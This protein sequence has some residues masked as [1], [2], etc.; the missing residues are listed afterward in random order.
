M[1]DC[2]TIDDL[3]PN[4]IAQI[5]YNQIVEEHLWRV[6]LIKEIIDVKFGCLVTPEGWTYEELGD[7]LHF[8]CVS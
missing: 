1:K 6:S 2:L 7:I 4:C 8:A 5:K 3:S